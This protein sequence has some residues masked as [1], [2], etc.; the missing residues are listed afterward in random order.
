M[1]SLVVILAA[2]AASSVFSTKA[3][4]TVQDRPHNVIIFVADGLRGSVVDAHLTPALDALRR[5]GVSF[6]N[7]H[8]LY[9]TVTTA[10]ASVIATGHYL[11]DTGNFSNAIYAGYPVQSAKGTK[12]VTPYL[13]DDVVLGDLDAHLGGNY[14]TE[15]TLLAAARRQGYSTAAIGKLGPALIQDHVDRGQVTLVLDDRSNVTGSDD[16]QD[17]VPV[18]PELAEALKRAGLPLTPPL[19]DRP[20][21]AQQTY[22]ADVASKAALPLLKAKGRPFVMVFWMRDPDITQH[23]QLDSRPGIVPGI[24]GSTSLEAIRNS[25][26]TLARLREAVDHLG[27][28][29]TTDIVVTS[30]HGFSTI[31]KQSQT[32]HSSRCDYADVDKGEVPPGFLAMDLGEALKLPVWDADSGAVPVRESGGCGQLD[33]SGHA[34]H[35]TNGDAILGTDPNHPDLVVA[36]G[37]GSSLVYPVGDAA[38]PM[39]AA[40]VGFFLRQDYVGGIFVDPKFGRIPGTIPLSDVG[41]VGSARTPHPAI[42]ISFRSYSSGCDSPFR[43][44]VELADSSYGQGQGMHG[45]F[46]R[47][48]TFNFMAATG[49]DFRK[50]FVDP[51]PVSNADIVPTIATIL[52]IHIPAEGRL[53]GRTIAEALPGGAVPAFQRKTC[54]YPAAELGGGAHEDQPP[55]LHLQPA[56]ALQMVGGTRY[57]DAGGFIGRT[58]GLPTEGGEIC[59]V[60]H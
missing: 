34:K 37:A 57:F 47:A 58:L 25:D 42:V 55:L 6:P 53:I 48:D 7:S 27:L 52:N 14:L 40:A 3:Q 51:A 13:E 45:A 15:E 49:P 30:D 39:V 2:L 35:P 43:C 28:S 22:Y 16:K 18:N 19:L 41:L 31:S 60:I 24:N 59:T 32:S 26:R 4:A 38:E 17:G 29:A 44:G 54:L 5:E 1:R 56:L 23:G 36:S 50:G 20:N 8:S 33:T 21:L 11:G 46:S 12:S 9:P 10:N